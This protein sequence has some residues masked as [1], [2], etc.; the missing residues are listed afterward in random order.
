MRRLRRLPQ[1]YNGSRATVEIEGGQSTSLVDIADRQIISQASL[2]VE[3]EDVAGAVAQV[4]TIA[5]TRGGF[6][7]QVATTVVRRGD[8]GQTLWY[9]CR[10]GS[11]L[12]PWKA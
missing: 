11:S 10:R 3:V 8:S 12:T 4:R 2:S 1:I 9:A 6:I 5:E 7:S